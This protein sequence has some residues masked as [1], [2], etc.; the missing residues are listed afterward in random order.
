MISQNRYIQ[1][2]RIFKQVFALK[3]I[4]SHNDII[5][6]FSGFFKYRAENRRI[7]YKRTDSDVQI[8][9]LKAFG[10]LLNGENRYNYYKA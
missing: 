10:G 2:I 4:I 1:E 6:D 9:I 8:A 3:G 5:Q 7:V